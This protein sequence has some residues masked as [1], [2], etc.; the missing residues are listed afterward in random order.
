M[1][2]IALLLGLFLEHRLTRLFS[3]REL[4][5]FDAWFDLVLGMMAPLTGLPAVALAMIAVLLP[6]APVAWVCLAFPDTW[7]GLPYLAFAL[8]LLLV[9]LGPR[10]LAEDVADFAAAVR[11]ADAE[12]ARRAGKALLERD[13]TRLDDAERV[14]R[15]REAVFVQANNRLFG[16]VFWFVLLGPLGPAGALMFRMA[17]LL[18]RRVAFKI[19]RREEEGRS[20]PAC[21]GAVRAVHGVLAWPP[22]RLLALT[23]ALAGSFDEAVN[24]WRAFSQSCT[25]RFFEANDDVLACVGSAALGGVGGDDPAPVDDAQAVEQA[26][27]LVDRTFWVWVT[28]IALLTLVGSVR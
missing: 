15:L 22:S 21:V 13:A 28:A 16:V 1:L 9:S 14:R 20:A 25:A 27:R 10:N 5:A 8:L 12:G 23:Y 4:R 17:D 2:L 3:L 19:A 7:L 24:D 26:L 18:R 6:V 11:G